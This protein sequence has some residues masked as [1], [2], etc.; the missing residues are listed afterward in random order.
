MNPRDSCLNCIYGRKWKPSG[1]CRCDLMQ[2]AVD[3]HTSRTCAYFTA[4]EVF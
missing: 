4:A 2:K 3:C 1:Y